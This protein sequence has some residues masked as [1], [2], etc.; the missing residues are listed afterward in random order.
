VT[1]DRCYQPLVTGEHGVGCCPLKPRRAAA[2]K[3]DTLVGGFWAQNA[4]REPRYF[5]SQKAYER[6]L[7]ADGMMLKPK[8]VAGDRAID[9]QTLANAR[10]LVSRSR[11]IASAPETR[12]ETLRMTTRVLDATLTVRAEA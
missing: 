9:P 12:L 11:S 2:V 3:P 8:R 10:E 5:D 1:C 6:A 7:D 4:W